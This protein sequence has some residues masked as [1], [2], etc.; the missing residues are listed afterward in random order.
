MAIAGAR[1][2]NSAGRPGE[3]EQH[4]SQVGSIRQALRIGRF[5]RGSA[6]AAHLADF[7][8]ERNGRPPAAH[9]DVAN[10]RVA[11]RI[12]RRSR[13]QLNAVPPAALTATARRAGGELAWTASPARGPRPVPGS[14]LPRA[15]Q[16]GAEARQLY[17]GPAVDKLTPMGATDAPRPPQSTWPR[18]PTPTTSGPPGWRSGPN[19][20]LP[21]LPGK[22]SR[23]TAWINSG[24]IHGQR[25]HE[26][27]AILGRRSLGKPV[28]SGRPQ[29]TRRLLQYRQGQI[30][31]APRAGRAV[32]PRADARSG[33]RWHRG[34]YG[35]SIIQ[36]LFGPQWR[37]PGMLQIDT[38]GPP[39]HGARA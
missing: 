14:A 38:D 29:L 31:R 35:E 22:G 25:P 12:W 20:Q 26:T 10:S 4:S 15:Q 39:A 17:E 28:R 3:S 33:L 1:C 13:N 24:K 16:P 19:P 23:R 36:R 37:Q 32:G 11:L 7:V 5:R 2:G 34:K 21:V 27:E 8:R 9:G 18:G 6:S 30:Q